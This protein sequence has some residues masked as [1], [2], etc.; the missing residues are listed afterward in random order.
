MQQGTPSPSTSRPRPGFCKEVGN[1]MGRWRRKYHEVFPKL[2][3]EQ[4]FLNCVLSGPTCGALN[5]AA[6]AQA[7]GLICRELG[8]KTVK[9]PRQI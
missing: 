4:P 7:Q 2:S 6:Q 9:I 8:S 3:L 5:A 1:V